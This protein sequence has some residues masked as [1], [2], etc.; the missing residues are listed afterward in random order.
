MNVVEL[1][2]MIAQEL[3]LE[4][5]HSFSLIRQACV[6]TARARLFER[7]R[8]QMS[9]MHEHTAVSARQP[10][11]AKPLLYREA[12]EL[13]TKGF[14]IG[15]SIRTIQFVCGTVPG[16]QCTNTA[17]VASLFSMTPYLRSAYFFG[18][19]WTPSPGDFEVK[20]GILGSVERLEFAAVSSR[21][22]CDPY[23]VILLCKAINKLDFFGCNFGTPSQTPSVAPVPC[24]EVTVEWS[25]LKTPIPVA[26]AHNVEV[27]DREGTSVVAVA[28]TIRRASVE[29]I[30]QLTVSSGPVVTRVSLPSW[31]FE[32]I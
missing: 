25:T 10:Q 19:E 2:E 8:V 28:D 20:H 16:N 26:N 12:V 3:G 11:K 24:A 23:Q 18:L 7:I 15:E 1:N 6:S 5:M 14:A 32:Y 29:T 30:E 22:D 13:L 4:D 31:Y 17:N 21:D 9:R 27:L